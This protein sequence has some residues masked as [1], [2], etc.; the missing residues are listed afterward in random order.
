MN[1][2]ITISS[3]GKILD[4]NRHFKVIAGPGAGK[5]HWL[6]GH[7][8]NVLQNASN[9]TANSRI[10]CITYTAVGAEEMSKRLGANTDRVDISTIHS[11]LYINV[12]KPYVHLLVD[13]NNERIVNVEKL[14]GHFENIAT[15]G[16][17]FQWQKEVNNLR[18]INN[19][20]EIKEC[21]ESLD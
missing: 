15:G 2:R 18:Y 20:E 8:K 5:T 13:E 16:K 10:A 7:I 21:L 9:F 4:L 3:D 19:K 12:V 1:K 17:I 14:D 6:I 11:F